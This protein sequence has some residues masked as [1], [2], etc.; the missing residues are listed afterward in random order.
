[1]EV[2]GSYFQ[3]LLQLMMRNVIVAAFLLYAHNAFSQPDGSHGNAMSTPSSH[4]AWLVNDPSYFHEFSKAVL[5]D[6]RNDS[7]SMAK[8]VEISDYFLPRTD[9]FTDG[10]VID[11]MEH[12]FWGMR[13]GLAIELG[14]LDG[15]PGT[16]SMTYEYEKSLNWR[17]IL[18]EGN[19]SYKDNLIKHSPLA[20]SVSAAIC[21]TPSTVHFSHSQY[22]GGIVE[23]MGLDFMKQ[24]HPEV[25][26]A[27][28][29]PGNVSSLNFSSIPQLVKPVECIPISH[30]LHKAHVK[31][32]NYFILDVEVSL[33]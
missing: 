24:Y 29:P 13:D 4:S 7:D 20:L 10:E 25:Y 33:V 19:P 6:V 16:R 27:C 17:R 2:D 23:F 28:V 8:F 21:S 31:H 1:M 15:S 5:L 26:N 9:A 18:I 14:A 11:A 22:V 3:Y 12:Y 30:V 32:V